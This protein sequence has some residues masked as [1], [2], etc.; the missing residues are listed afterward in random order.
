MA[1][2]LG[3]RVE[4]QGA[5]PAATRGR[6]S[7]GILAE[8]FGYASEQ[9]L[10]MALGAVAGLLVARHLGPARLGTL[11]FA[12]TVFGI[13]SPMALLGMPGVLV[14]E[15][16]IRRDWQ[17]LMA[18][19]LD[20][21]LPAAAV[22]SVVGFLVV[23]GAGGFDRDAL[24][25]ATVLLP[26]PFIAVNESV[27]AYLQATGRM[28]QVVVAGVVAAV[29]ATAMKVGGVLQQAPVW[30]FAAL[31]V[32][33]GLMVTVGLLVG[34]PAKVRLSAWRRH[35]NVRTS[36]RLM[37]ESWPL[38]VAGV[39]LSL[40]M[41]ADVLMLGL[42]ASDAETGIYT[43]AA[44][45]SEVWYFIPVA[46]AGA[47]RPRLARAFTSGRLRHYEQATQ[48]F[49]TA[50]AASSLVGVVLVLVAGD[51][52]IRLLYGPQFLAAAPVLRVHVLAAP[53]VFLGVA[54][55]QWFLDRQMTR[56]VMWRSA[57]GAATNI[58]SNLVLI[59]LHGALGAAISTLLAYAVA[60]VLFNGWKAETRPLLAMQLRA[61][62]GRWPRS[63]HEVDA[64]GGDVD[65]TQ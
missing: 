1:D 39:A 23:A 60:G 18:S 30:V 46:A 62:V 36:S 35:A 20:R 27:R 26:A 12:V 54:G 41:K 14:R 24:L 22:A 19:A 21:Q 29:V 51:H 55:T 16:S 38:L 58:V 43:A 25:L 52:L 9:A 64:S 47:A 40:Y 7:G 3:G 31:V 59:P 11:S 49:M 33:D 32:A 34:L 17:P 8:A 63:S 37:R 6:G 2:L 13:L 50:L 28:R 57:A 56:A 65:R 10:R 48:K 4:H 45:V 5:A 61:V 53:F 15:F 42:L 44:R